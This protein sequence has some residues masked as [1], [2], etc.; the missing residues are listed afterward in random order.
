MKYSIEMALGG[1]T[2]MPSSMKV[3]SDV[4]KLLGGINIREQGELISL[5][6]FPE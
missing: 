4:R 2:Y 6:F 3:G 5:L 1:M